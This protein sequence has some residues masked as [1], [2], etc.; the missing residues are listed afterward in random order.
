MGSYI[1][2][3][4]SDAFGKKL[5][6]TYSVTPDYENESDVVVQPYN[7]ILTLARLTEHADSVRAPHLE[8]Y[9]TTQTSSIELQSTHQS[10]LRLSTQVVVLDNTALTRIAEDRLR[11]SAPSI[12]QVRKS[13]LGPHGIM[14][15]LLDRSIRLYPL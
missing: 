8:A 14:S 5:V 15:S 2:E 3:Q 12:D 6:Q 7:S 10:S 1:L 13:L 4:L 11:L 9:N